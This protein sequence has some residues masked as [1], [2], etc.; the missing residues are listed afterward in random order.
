MACDLTRF[1]SIQ[2]HDL[3]RGVAEHVL[4][5]EPDIDRCAGE[6]KWFDRMLWAN[7]VAAH[8]VWR[9]RTV[10]EMSIA[11]AESRRSAVQ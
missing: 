1:G 10:M 8:T 3:S 5:L 4:N 11:Q 2:L 6:A 7:C 9:S